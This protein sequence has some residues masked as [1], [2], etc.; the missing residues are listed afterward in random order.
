MLPHPG[1]KP[2]EWFIEEEEIA[3]K[4][5]NAGYRKAALHPAREIMHHLPLL[6]PEPER[7]KHGLNAAAVIGHCP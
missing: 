5:E 4:E 3:I 1:I 2:P 6:A 7:G